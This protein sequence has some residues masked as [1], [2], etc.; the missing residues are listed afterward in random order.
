MYIYLHLHAFVWVVTSPFPSSK[1]SAPQ[2]R[3]TGALKPSLRQIAVRL[4]LAELARSES[5]PSPRTASVPPGRAQSVANS[6]RT[7]HY[8]PE[9]RLRASARGGSKNETTPLQIT[10]Q[11]VA[12]KSGCVPANRLRH[13]TKTERSFPSYLVCNVEYSHLPNSARTELLHEGKTWRYIAVR[14]CIHCFRRHP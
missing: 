8:R 7:E 10:T 12:H 6:T 14:C 5:R 11:Y 3:P 1:Y 2:Q 4:Q 13:S 9:I